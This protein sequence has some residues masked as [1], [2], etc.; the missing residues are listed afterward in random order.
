MMIRRDYDIW[1]M[2]D[3]FMNVGNLDRVSIGSFSSS[4]S[5]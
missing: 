5:F 4:C 3:G 2:I 1:F